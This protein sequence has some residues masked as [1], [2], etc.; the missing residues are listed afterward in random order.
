MRMAAYRLM[1]AI[2]LDNDASNRFF[3]MV[4]SITFT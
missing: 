1:V 2:I 3:S 4:I